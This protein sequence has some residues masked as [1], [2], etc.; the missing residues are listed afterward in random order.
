MRH[1]LLLAAAASGLAQNQSAT[2]NELNRQ[3]F[4]K[5]ARLSLNNLMRTPVAP[6]PPTPCSIPLKNVLRGVRTSPMPQHRPDVDQFPMRHVQVPAPSC[7]EA[8]R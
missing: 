7:E 2:P 1:L 6:Q 5:H 4:E 3:L 8:G